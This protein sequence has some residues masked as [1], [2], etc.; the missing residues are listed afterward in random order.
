MQYS[1]EDHFHR[2][3]VRGKPLYL[4]VI[5]LLIASF[6]ALPV[7]KVDITFS[8]RGILRTEENAS[9]I[10]APVGG[11]IA[12]ILIKKNGFVNKHDTLIILN[13]EAIKNEIADSRAANL[14]IKSYMDDLNMLINGREVVGTTRYNQAMMEYEHELSLLKSELVYIREIHDTNKDLYEEGY[15]ARLDYESSRKQLLS[16][17]TRLEVRK[18]EFQNRW[19][20]E[21]SAYKLEYLQLNTR[22]AHLKKT[23][24]LHYIK[25]PVTGYIADYSDLTTGSF[26]A[27]NDVIARIV[28]DRELVATCMVPADKISRI[29]TGQKVN[30][31]IDTYPGSTYGRIEGTVV[32]IPED[33]TIHSG[34]PGFPIICKIEQGFQYS[35][36][37]D[38]AVLKSGMTFTALFL[39]AK[40]TL[41]QLI[42]EKGEKLI[43]HS[44]DI[45]LNEKKQ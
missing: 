25:A 40:K 10:I 5:V 7:V 41:W 37:Y 22:L 36:K 35:S 45:P 33:A 43:L 30:L 28:P 32:S 14:L 18:R 23:M 2:N 8:T 3:N 42:I 6:I 17:E 13:H 20:S 15:L 16:A 29:R 1:A 34:I 24:E 9:R 4:L 38:D 26:I 19:Q 27:S 44:P 31:N 39:V 12:C 11:E 21:L